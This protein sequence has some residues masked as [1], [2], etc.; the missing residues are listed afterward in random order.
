MAGG[1]IETIKERV[2]IVDLIGSSVQLR[3]A[4]RSFKGLCPFHDEKSPSFVVYPESQSYHCFGCGKSGDIFTYVMD[5]ENLDFRDALR[6]L[7]DRAG[8]E[9]ESRR[10]TQADPARDRERDRLIE[11]NERAAAYFAN[12]LWT[13]PAAQEAR[14]L[15][16]RRGL[17]RATADKFGLGFAP[18]SFDALKSHFLARS[19]SE[20]ELLTAGLL[21]QHETSGRT[22]DRFRN[23]VMFPIR[24][25]DGQTIGFGARALGDEK[26]KYLNSPQS[27]IFDKR[28]V[29][30][31]LDKAYDSIRRERSM[32]IV[33]G[34]MDAIAA[35][36]FGYDNVVASMGT[37]VTPNQVASIRRY[38]DRVYLSLDADTAGQMATLRGIDAMRESF[39]DDERAD[40]RPNQMVRFERTIGAEIRIVVLPEGKDPDEFI[41]S[42]ADQW[43]DV[44]RNAAPLVEYY[45][46][47]ALADIDRSPMERAKALREVAIPILDEIGDPD[48]LTHYVGMTARLLEYPDEEVRRA[49]LRRSRSQPSRTT[50][51]R[52]TPERGVSDRPNASDP[53]RYL[54]SLILNFPQAGATELPSLRREDVLDGR[55]RT[56]LDQLLE[57]GASYD[58]MLGALPIELMEY[59]VELH[60]SLESAPGGPPRPP[61]LEIPNAIRRL[62]RMRHDERL[63]QVRAELEQAKKAGDAVLVAEYTQRMSE[64]A[65]QRTSFAPSQSPYFKDL[66][67][68]PVGAR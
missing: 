66:R 52:P 15:L 44:L 64:L 53:E 1:S 20:E 26:P 43:P 17:D 3:Q 35:H 61:S 65:T 49:M 9:L 14:A 16:E 37:A 58:A 19:A 29:L 38:L 30:Y 22:Y 62:A 41:R 28:S 46:T 56:I 39:A 63:R 31:A 59:A 27:P 54:V 57:S 42:H 55:H 18:N 45:L 24:N 12:L 34:Y 60:D 32:V 8:V 33:E 7:A 36:Q 40:V 21:S 25:R 48:V 2:D 6:Q 10:Q 47:H 11:L 13:S 67:S 68:E 50:A 51:T 5:T 23:R 4:G